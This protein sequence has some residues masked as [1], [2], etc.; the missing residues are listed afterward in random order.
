MLRACVLV[1][2]TAAALVASLVRFGNFLGFLK[3]VALLVVLFCFLIFIIYRRVIVAYNVAAVGRGHNSQRAIFLQC[4]IFL[5]ISRVVHILHV[6]VVVV[7][8]LLIVIVLLAS[9]IIL[10]FVDGLLVKLVRSIISSCTLLAFR[11]NANKLFASWHATSDHFN[12]IMLIVVIFFFASTL[13][14]AQGI[15]F[16]VLLSVIHVLLVDTHLLESGQGHSHGQGAS[17]LL[18]ERLKLLLQMICVLVEKTAAKDAA[19]LEK[20]KL[21]LNGLLHGLLTILITLFD[22]DVFFLSLL[23]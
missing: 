19:L 7:R 20:L 22:L 11:F 6:I 8:T 10:F 13:L 4:V 5:F 15:L 21:G 3:L 12:S 9:F 16:L 14:F 17:S 2:G 1:A 18:L 23:V